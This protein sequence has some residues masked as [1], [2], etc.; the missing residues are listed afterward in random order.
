MTSSIRDI[1]YQLRQGHLIALADETGWSV[2]ADPLS[3]VAVG[4][5]LTLT[6]TGTWPTLLI[7]QARQLSLYLTTVPDIAWDLV[8]FAENPLTVVYEGGKNLAPAFLTNRPLIAIRR[9]LSPEVVR[10]I[11]G[12]GKGLLTIPLESKT[13]SD[14]IASAVTDRFGNPPVPVQLPR[15]MQLGVNGEIKFLRK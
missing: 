1:T 3:D 13:L 7:D 10:L 8:E 14:A 11:G 4:Q 15:I 12:F 5:L 2:A 6:P 9:A